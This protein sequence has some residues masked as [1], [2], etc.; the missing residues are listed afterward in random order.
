MAGGEDG[1]LGRQ[2]IARA[3]GSTT[4]LG[5][6]DGCGVKRGDRLVLE[7]PGGGGWGSLIDLADS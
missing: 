3:D 5:S 6:V 1:Q 4:A 2:H 7:T